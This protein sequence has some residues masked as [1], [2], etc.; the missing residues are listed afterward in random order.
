MTFYFV[1]AIIEVFEAIVMGEIDVKKIEKGLLEQLRDITVERANLEEENKLCE[2]SCKNVKKMINQIEKSIEHASF[3]DELN[4]KEKMDSYSDEEKE[5]HV[6]LQIRRVIHFICNNDS[7]DLE[8][9]ENDFRSSEVY[10]N[11]C[12]IK[13]G[14]WKKSTEK[15][16]IEYKKAK[17]NYLT[18]KIKDNQEII[19]AIEDRTKETVGVLPMD[20]IDNLSSTKEARKQ[21]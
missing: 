5:N 11:L 12:D 17:L 18:K 14:Y 8:T 16:Y 3:L 20:Y 4:S 7:I 21:V 9:A 15:V 13:T 1:I 6:R 19:T 2:E 10:N